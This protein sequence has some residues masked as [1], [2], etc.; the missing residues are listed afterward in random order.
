MCGGEWCIAGTRL[1]RGAM[2]AYARLMGFDG[3]RVNWPYIRDNE[4]D[5]LFAQE[6]HAPRPQH[7]GAVDTE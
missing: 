3:L 2:K 6:F 5:M 1:S 4:W 7:P